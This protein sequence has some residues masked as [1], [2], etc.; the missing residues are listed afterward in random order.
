MLAT[1]PGRPRHRRQ[2][3]PGH[4]P[5]APQNVQRIRGSWDRGAW[6]G[7]G[8][9]CSA[10]TAAA[11]ALNPRFCW[12]GP[13]PIRALAGKLKGAS[14]RPRSR[15]ETNLP[16]GP[17]VDRPHADSTAAMTP[18]GPTAWARGPH[19]G[20]APARRLRGGPAP[21]GPRERRGAG[22]RGGNKGLRGCRP[23]QGGPWPRHAAGDR[24]IT[25]AD[26]PSWKV[27]RGTRSIRRR[28]RAWQTYGRAVPCYPV[29]Y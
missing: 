1:G 18:P 12:P 24:V 13:Q 25:A 8:G 3:D 22:S 10:A 28:G 26:Y 20:Y 7:Q 6:G 2:S 19:D 15:R 4:C 9:S 27:G 29:L 21:T 14:V 11:L 16:A 23:R 5:E 17:V